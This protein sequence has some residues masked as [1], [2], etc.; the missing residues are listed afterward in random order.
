MTSRTYE[1]TPFT[2]AWKRAEKAHKEHN[3]AAFWAALR[4]MAN[5]I[6][7]AWSA[8]KTLAMIPTD[9]DEG[10]KF[11]TEV[12]DAQVEKD[13][14][15]YRSW[16]E[17]RL[18]YRQYKAATEFGKGQ[19]LRGMATTCTKVDHWFFLLTEAEQGG[20]AYQQA[21]SWARNNM[22]KPE[23]WVQH[24]L[25]IYCKKELHAFYMELTG[26]QLQRKDPE[27][28]LSGFVSRP[29]LH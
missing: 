17:I 8:A 18:N 15:L 5:Q 16:N 11:F 21:I 22:P 28:I 9:T 12:I 29:I 14:T 23:Q 20:A 6:N 19:I 10:R 27:H 13:L 4:E 1:D 3:D 7:G 25:Q 26:E 24:Y 2:R